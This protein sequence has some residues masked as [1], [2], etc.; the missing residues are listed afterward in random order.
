M[1][2][3]NQAVKFRAK[4]VGCDGG[5]VPSDPFFVFGGSILRQ[6][7]IRSMDQGDECFEFQAQPQLAPVSTPIEDPTISWDDAG[8]LSPRWRKFAF[9]KC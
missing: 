9:R 8:A 6:A 5:S 2:H 3:C 1:C 4:P 7:M